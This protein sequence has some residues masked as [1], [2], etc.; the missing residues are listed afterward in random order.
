MRLDVAKNVNLISVVYLFECS[1]ANLHAHKEF[2]VGAY[3]LAVNTRSPD[4]VR[5]IRAA[6]PVCR[7]MTE[8]GKILNP[9][10]NIFRDQ[11]IAGASPLRINTLLSTDGLYFLYMMSVLATYFTPDVTTLPS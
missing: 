2:E 9:E 5:V 8:R 3:R 11:P 6:K 4:N 10:Y 7:R 1:L